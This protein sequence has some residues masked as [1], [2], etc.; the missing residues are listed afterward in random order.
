MHADEHKLNSLTK[1]VIG[2]SFEVANTLGRGFV[3]KVYANALGLELSSRGIN[4]KREFQVKVFYKGKV[5]GDFVIDLWIENSLLV[6]T[7]ATSDLNN[8]HMAQ[9]L[10]YLKASNLPLAL[11]INFGSAS[12]QAKRIVNSL[13]RR[14]ICGNLSNLC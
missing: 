2:A 8:L 1:V 13:N 3:E 10:N 6:E 7:K 5:A 4:V 11:L 12:V 14:R 9:S